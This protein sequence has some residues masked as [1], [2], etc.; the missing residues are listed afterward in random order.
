MNPNASCSFMPA[1]SRNAAVQHELAVGLG[2]SL[3]LRPP[4]VFSVKLP[5]HGEPVSLLPSR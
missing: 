4:V 3:A 2:N 1:W 5:S